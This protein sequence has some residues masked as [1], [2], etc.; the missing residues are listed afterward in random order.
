MTNLAPKKLTGWLILFIILI[1]PLQFGGAAQSLTRVAEAFR[2]YLAEYPSLS[3]AIL[4]YQLFTGGSI[5]VW[6]A[7]HPVRAR[8]QNWFA[9][10]VLIG[11]GIRLAL[12][13]RR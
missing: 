2:P 6:V 3:K 5:A 13:D 4:V 1:G 8:L 11:L 12:T 10:F 7:R 9:G